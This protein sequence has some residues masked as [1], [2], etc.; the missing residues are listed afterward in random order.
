MPSVRI[1][2][3]KLIRFWKKK[4]PSGQLRNNPDFIVYYE[5]LR[6]IRKQAVSIDDELEAIAT[7]LHKIYEKKWDNYENEFL[8]YHGTIFLM[9]DNQLGR[10]VREMFSQFKFNSVKSIIDWI[11]ENY[12][13]ETF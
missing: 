12:T 10:P 3:P 2:I 13:L 7:F 8:V 6:E 9:E 5:Q 4:L 1:D 11:K